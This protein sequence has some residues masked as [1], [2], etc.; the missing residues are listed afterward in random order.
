MRAPKSGPIWGLDPGSVVR[1]SSS[2]S[3]SSV[4]SD[5]KLCCL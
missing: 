2:S 5:L 1:R 4:E 3:I